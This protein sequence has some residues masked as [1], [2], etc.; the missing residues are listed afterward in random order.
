[1]SEE[2][3]TAWMKVAP[4]L[5]GIAALAIL[6]DMGIRSDRAKNSP[7]A[8]LEQSVSRLRVGMSRGEAATALEAYQLIGSAGS[9]THL[10]DFFLDPASG[11]VARLRFKR[12]GN[13]LNG[14]TRLT[15]V[16]WGV[17][18]PSTTR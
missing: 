3:R 7:G 5:L 11:G 16:E 6:F 1:M 9:M 8:A 2:P 15:L 12:T 4:R 14:T 13:V 18:I 10:N 17:Q